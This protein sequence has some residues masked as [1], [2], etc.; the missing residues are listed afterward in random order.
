MKD[1]E[2]QRVVATHKVGFRNRLEITD[3][4]IRDKRV[5]IPYSLIK[6]CSI[7]SYGVPDKCAVKYI[8]QS[9][10]ERRVGF[11]GPAIEV[12]SDIIRTSMQCGHRISR[13]PSPKIVQM[14][15]QLRS[16]GIESELIEPEV[17]Y[18]EQG[19]SSWRLELG[20]LTPRGTNIDTVRLRETGQITGSAGM[21]YTAELHIQY[22]VDYMIQI[23]H[24]PHI[25]CEGR[26]EKKFP[27]RVVDYH[28]AGA[29]LAETLNEDTQLRQLLVKAKAPAI[30]VKG[31]NIRI[32]DKKLPTVKLFQCI[33]RI[34]EYIRKEAS[35]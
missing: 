23:E 7:Y 1:V 28:W 11:G 8:D 10:L 13:Q 2:S 22:S 30:E 9:G 12:Y 5:N 26:P 34:A 4:G 17:E 32:Q 29:S 35:W 21:Y 25:S 20:S 33:D 27:G 3:K 24:I 6:R 19:D 14:G 31:N 16:V 18:N 15:N